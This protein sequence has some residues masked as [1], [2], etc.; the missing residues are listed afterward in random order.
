MAACFRATREKHLAE[1]EE[2]DKEEW[3]GHTNPHA[4]IEVY[5]KNIDDTSEGN[6]FFHAKRLE[7]IELLKYMRDKESE[8]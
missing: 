8:Q 7:M 1:G 6:N 4:W 3:G 5:E 2:W